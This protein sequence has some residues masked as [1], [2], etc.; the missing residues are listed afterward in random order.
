MYKSVY[1]PG[2]YTLYRGSNEC[3]RLLLEAG[4]DPNLTD[5][6]ESSPLM[7]AIHQRS[8]KMVELLIK[9]S[10]TDLSIQVCLVTL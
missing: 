10:K 3:V 8:V 2:T 5:K 7:V 9:Y 1:Y 4:A 6:S